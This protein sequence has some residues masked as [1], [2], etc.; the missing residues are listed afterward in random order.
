MLVVTSGANRVDE[1]RIAALLGEPLGKA[2]ARFVREVTGFPIGGVAPIGHATA[3]VTFVDEDLLAHR[4]I[5]AAAGH[6][7][8]LFRLEPADLPRMTGAPAVKVSP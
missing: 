2:D 6:P 5:W 7:N 4:E 3:L 1:A 8:A